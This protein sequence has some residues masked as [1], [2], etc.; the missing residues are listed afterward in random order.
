V[1]VYMCVCVCVCARARAHA[2]VPLNIFLPSS[3]RNSTYTHNGDLN[4]SQRSVMLALF[5]S[6]QSI[7]GAL[8]W[9]TILTPSPDQNPFYY[10][11]KIS[12]T[13]LSVNFHLTRSWPNCVEFDMFPTLCHDL[14]PDKIVYQQFWN[15]QPSSYKIKIPLEIPGPLKT[16]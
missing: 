2:C 13:L 10:K 9:W 8:L 11:V 14:H 15:V 7:W 5:L 1:C 6:S 4:V 16:P 3:F 12:S